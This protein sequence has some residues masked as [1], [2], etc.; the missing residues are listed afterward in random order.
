MSPFTLENKHILITGAAGGIGRELAQIC[1]EL[2]AVLILADR[3][4]PTDLACAL[5][6]QGAK[7]EAIGFDA[8]DKASIEEAIARL[9]RID[10]LVANAGYCPWDSWDDENWESVLNAVIDVNL[11]GVIYLTRCVLKKMIAQGSGQM[12]L[13]TSVAARMGGLKA[14]P[15]YVAAK[16]GVTSFVKWL[17]RVAAPHDIPVN[18]VAPGATQTAMTENQAISTD[19]IPMGRMAHPREIALPIAFLC[20]EGASYI[21]GA[22]LD[23]N[24]GV[25]MN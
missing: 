10:V 15:H 16:G 18:C 17:A 21:S 7:A 1:A 8:G 6:R 14:S 22:T 5:R 9:G 24:G 11:A 19:G 12:V 20:S 3:Q 2:G 23:V 25:Y 13:V 4:A